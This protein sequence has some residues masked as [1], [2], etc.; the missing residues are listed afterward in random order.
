MVVLV[1]IETWVISKGALKGGGVERKDGV[2]RGRSV[3]S[4]GFGGPCVCLGVVQLL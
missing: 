4:A 2:S 3:G 1:E